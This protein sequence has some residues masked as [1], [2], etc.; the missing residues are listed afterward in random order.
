V[1]VGD[2]VE[3]M[4]GLP[5]RCVDLVFADPPY[6]L[7][8]DGDLWRPD[9]TKVDAADDL[10]DRFS[11]P[12][13]YDG[14][15]RDWLAA[16]RRVMKDDA[17]LWVIGSYHNIYRVGAILMDLGFWILN[18]IV[19]IKTNPTPQMRGV[20]FC[21]AHETLLWV[22]KSQAAT[23]Y[24]FNYRGAK[25]GNEDRQMRSDWYMP[26]CSGAERIQVNGLKAHSTQKPEALL[27]RVISTTSNV[28]DIVLDPFCGS[29][30]TAA[31]AKRLGRHFIT[32]DR[33]EG[34]VEIARSR[35]AEVVP[36]L[37]DHDPT[38]VGDP[39]PKVP[40]VTLVEQRLAPAGARLRLVKGT[41]TALINADG[42]VTAEGYRGSIHRVSARC[43]GVPASN[44]WTAWALID[45]VTG[46][47]TLLDEIRRQFAT[48]MRTPG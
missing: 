10:W 25:A 31:V 2:C 15:T 32:I 35:I 43:L 36:A 21:N 12:E 5:E 26:I 46:D 48:L 7:R 42:S 23:K 29:G 6:N 33:D 22:K 13:E 44:G 19:W 18:D 4:N 40:F 16:A 39:I 30:T 38:P 14:F 1:L 11:S 28:G 27:H 34:Y 17:T 8:L 24:T 45:P 37:L 9:D 47:C 41:A 20:R 3:V